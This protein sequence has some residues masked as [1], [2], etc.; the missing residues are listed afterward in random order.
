[1]KPN[2]ETSA[3]FAEVLVSP[4]FRAAVNVAFAENP[5]DYAEHKD[6]AET[7][8]INSLYGNFS[9]SQRIWNVR[10]HA[11]MAVATGSE[12]GAFNDYL[13]NQGG[14]AEPSRLEARDLGDGASEIVRTNGLILGLHKIYDEP[15]DFMEDA[16]SAIEGRKKQVRGS[17]GPE[18]Y[19]TALKFFTDKYQEFPS[20]HLDKTV[21]K[22]QIDEAMTGFLQITKRDKPNFV[23]MTNLYVAIR[24]LPRG[25]FDGMFS[26]DILLHSLE[27]LPTYNARTVQIMIAALGKLD[28]SV[29]GET[30]ATLID[31]GLRKSKG[32]EKTANMHQTARAI[33]ALPTS[34]AA[35]RTFDTFL[36]TRNNLEY[37]QD[38]EGLDALNFS[39]A[40]IA[41]NVIQDPAL[42]IDVKQLA[43]TCAANAVRLYRQKESTGDV[44]TAELQRLKTTV[45]R[46][47]SNFNAI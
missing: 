18:N 40:Q 15:I 46:I 25:T 11:A 28:L 19:A 12:L 34:R 7:L 6:F 24:T 10:H 42:F 20:S 1:M 8:I 31:L 16:L 37:P 9:N 39:L 33:A 22:S 23:E 13:Q 32:L 21:I 44:T 26:N 27:Q 45:R 3:A 43:E 14:E 35:D 17:V 4:D 5:D 41:Q 36:K 30:G 47:V 29:T 38:L 2:V